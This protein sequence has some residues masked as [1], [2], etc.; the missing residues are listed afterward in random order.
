M[1]F[2]L[3]AAIGAQLHYRD[4]P[5]VALCGDGG[6]SMLLGEFLTA[7][8][9]ALPLTVV[10][11]NNG[12]L[13]LI[14]VEQKVHGHPDFETELPDLDF[15][16][17]A[18]LCGGDGAR[19]ENH[20][21]LDD[22]LRRAFDSKLPSIVDVKIDPEALLFPPRLDLQEAMGYGLAKIR[23]FFEGLEKSGGS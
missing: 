5:V 22:A 10:V 9:Y 4:R 3:P 14:E 1:A 20:A 16:A 19:V 15:A 2:A 11:F 12:K 6:L 7:V 17:F 13:G 21:E 8:K 18:R 23:G